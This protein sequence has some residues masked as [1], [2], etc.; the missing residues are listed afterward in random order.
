M[1]VIV[2][3][4]ELPEPVDINPDETIRICD[5]V[6][7]GTKRHKVP[8][9]MYVAAFKCED[10]LTL[11]RIRAYAVRVKELQACVAEL[12]SI[13]SRLAVQC[14]RPLDLEGIGKKS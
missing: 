2:H 10:H 6:G 9:R 12:K 7:R 1:S 13:A 8:M 5:E 3:T 14:N 11:S 4:G